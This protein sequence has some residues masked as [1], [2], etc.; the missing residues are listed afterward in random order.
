MTLED[1]IRNTKDLSKTP[2]LAEYKRLMDENAEWKATATRLRERLEKLTAILRNDCDIDASWDGLRKFWS[3]GLTE[4]GVLMRDR[5]CKAEAENARLQSLCVSAYKC[6]RHS[7]H[8]TCEDCIGMC[9]G[10]TL[11]S[12]MRKAGIEVGT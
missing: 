5:A 2:L 9:G 3:V 7:D 10:C 11:L 8:A 1:V 4:Q 6:A 12:A